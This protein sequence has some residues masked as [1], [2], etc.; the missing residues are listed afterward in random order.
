MPK[1]PIPCEHCGEVFGEVVLSKGPGGYSVAAKQA[2]F[3]LHDCIV[4]HTEQIKALQEQLVK[5]IRWLRCELVRLEA[6]CP[7]T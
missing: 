4:H 2:H 7:R 5:E 3:D 1:T 6:M